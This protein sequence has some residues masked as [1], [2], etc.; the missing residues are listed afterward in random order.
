LLVAAVQ[1]FLDIVAVVDLSKNT[2]SA[3]DRSCGRILVLIGIFKL[4]SS[5]VTPEGAKANSLE[6]R[7]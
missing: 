5:G 2:N 3:R 1:W 7:L 4:A 6:S